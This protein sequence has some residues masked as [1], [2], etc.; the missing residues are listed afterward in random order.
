MK[1]VTI[2]TRQFLALCLIAGGVAWAANTAIDETHRLIKGNLNVIGTTGL[3]GISTVVALDAGPQSKVGGVTIGSLL[4]SD[5]GLA[6]HACEFG[7]RALSTG[8]IQVTFTRAFTSLPQCQCTHRNTTNSNTCVL[9]AGTI[10]TVTTADFAV[11][12]GGSDVIDYF[13]CGDI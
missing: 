8:A 12:S 10:P 6:T 7:Y 5:G 13:C 9:N 4:A 11:A 2:T 1:S 3:R